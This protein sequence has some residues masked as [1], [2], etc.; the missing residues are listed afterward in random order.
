LS[1]LLGLTQQVLVVIGSEC[2][3]CW[4]HLEELDFTR[5][6]DLRFADGD[7][8]VTHLQRL[9]SLRRLNISE[10]FVDNGGD[11]GSAD[12]FA[13]MLRK[14]TPETIRD[15]VRPPGQRGDFML[16]GVRI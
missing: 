13:G 8:A 4:Q 1:G 14:A 2:G 15:W 6:V 9:P 5:C 7:D 12:R 11:N 16:N 10:H 3:R